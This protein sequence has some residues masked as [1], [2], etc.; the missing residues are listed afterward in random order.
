MLDGRWDSPKLGSGAI[1]RTDNTSSESTYSLTVEVMGAF[2]FFEVTSGRGF[3]H[4]ADVF[5]SR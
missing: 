3:R 1:P 5:E 2:A 4:D